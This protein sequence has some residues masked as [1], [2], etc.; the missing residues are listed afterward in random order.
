MRTTKRNKNGIMIGHFESRE[1]LEMWICDLKEMRGPFI[2][3]KRIA[4][5]CGVTETLV[6]ITLRKNGWYGYRRVKTENEK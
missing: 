3:Q 6:G 4:E 1:V 5:I 2:T